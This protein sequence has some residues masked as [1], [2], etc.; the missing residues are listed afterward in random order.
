VGQWLGVT[1][2]SLAQWQAASGTDRNSLFA[3]PLFVDVNGADNVLGA[4]ATSDGRDDDFHLQSESGSFH[5]GPWHR[6]RAR[7]LA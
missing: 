3:N 4:N 6:W 2:G 7:A 1:R 5:G